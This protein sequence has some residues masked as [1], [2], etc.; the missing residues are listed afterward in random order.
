MSTGHWDVHTK[1]KNGYDLSVEWDIGTLSQTY[2]T[3]PVDSARP[4]IGN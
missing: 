1:L 3:L 2:P 4:T